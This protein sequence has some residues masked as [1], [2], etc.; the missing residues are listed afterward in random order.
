[1]RYCKLIPSDELEIG[2]ILDECWNVRYRSL[3]ASKRTFALSSVPVP[4]N[5]YCARPGDSVAW[6]QAN[7][8]YTGCTRQHRLGVVLSLGSTSTQ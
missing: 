5:L 4:I 1:M 6:R 2:S 3:V 7:G 8:Y